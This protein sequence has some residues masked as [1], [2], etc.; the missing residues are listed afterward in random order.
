[1]NQIL[2]IMPSLNDTSLLASNAPPQPQTTTFPTPPRRD[3]KIKP[4]RAEHIETTEVSNNPQSEDN[5]KET[6]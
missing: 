4:K 1:V 6:A 5:E 3:Y 2:L